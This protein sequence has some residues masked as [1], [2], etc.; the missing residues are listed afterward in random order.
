M[1]VLRILLP[2]YAT[3]AREARG[4]LVQWLARGDRLPPVKPGR[5]AALA[6]AFA[7][8]PA[9]ALPSAALSRQHALHDAADA[10]WLR[11]DPGHARADLASLRLMRCGDLGLAPEEA[12]ALLRA[13]KPYFGDDG[14][15]LTAPQPDRWYLRGAA[16]ADLPRAPD[17]LDVLG[18]DLHAH[19]PEQRKW[20]RLLNEAQVALHHHP[21]NLARVE[22]G[23]LPANTLWFW[24]GGRSPDRVAATFAR[25]CGTDE[26]IAAYAEAAGAAHAATIAAAV[27]GEGGALIE[28]WTRASW[29]ALAA[30]LDALH[31]GVGRRYEAIV[32]ECWSGEA[33]RYRRSNRWRITRALAV[34]AS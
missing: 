10:A 6:R 26:L 20:K 8:A 19:L 1:S 4:P 34:P 9:G 2:A 29:D 24:G 3:V 13:L 21:V 32:L 25:W 7:L 5:A 11:A 33:F 28:C 15:E 17:P 31:A 22:R 12:D 30:T 27:Q 16:S 14:F 23:E 18:D